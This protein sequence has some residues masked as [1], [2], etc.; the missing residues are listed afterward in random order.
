[1]EGEL[2]VALKSDVLGE[3]T[4]IFLQ[5]F[6]D[7][8]DFVGIYGE[9]FITKQGKL[10]VLAKKV[11]L[12]SKTL[13]PLPSKHFGIEDIELKYRKRYLDLILD[14]NS[15]NTFKVRSVFTES[16]REWLLDHKFQEIGN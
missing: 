14:E 9:P 15:K 7:P 4:M 3:D 12:L 6:V 2:Q 11:E 8:G 10:A 13:R 1:M 16:L 5:E